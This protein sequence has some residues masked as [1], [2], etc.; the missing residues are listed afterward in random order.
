MQPPTTGQKYPSLPLWL[1]RRRQRTESLAEEIRVLYVALT[2][3][4][5]HLLLFGRAT[6]DDLIPATRVKYSG[7]LLVGQDLLQI[8]IGE[9]VQAKPFE[10]P[11]AE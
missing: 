3:A 8:E 1:A 5:N 2:R 6:A 9:T 4:E 7:P 11:A 10:L